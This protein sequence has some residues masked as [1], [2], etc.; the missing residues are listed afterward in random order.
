MD[1]QTETLIEMVRKY[2]PG[3]ATVEAAAAECGRFLESLGA[4]DAEKEAA[5]LGAVRYLKLET[6]REILHTRSLV[7]HREKWYR[8]TG[9]GNRHWP[10]LKTYLIGTKKWKQDNVDEIDRSSDE[11]V[12]LLDNPRS[13]DPFSCRGLVVGY[14]Q[15]GKTANMTAVIAKAVDAGYTSVIVLAGLTNKL[16]QQ[17]QRRFEKDIVARHRNAWRLQTN[18]DDLG[19]FQIPPDKGFLP[20]ADHAI[21]AVVKKNVSPLGR[22]IKTIEGTPPAALRELR[23]LVID[24]ECDQASVNS[25]SGEMN[26]TA[27]NAKIREL[28]GKLP[29]VSYVG[30]TATPFANVLINPYPNDNLKELDDLY[31][32]DFITAL[33]TPDGYFGARELFGRPSSLLD[34]ETDDDEGFDVICEVPSTHE[35]ALQPVKA[36]DRESFQ[37]SMPS[38]LEE[39]ILYFLA[40]CAVRR[41]RGDSEEHMSMLIHTSAFV[42]MHEKVAG[43]VEKWIDEVAPDLTRRGSEIADRLEAIWNREQR[44]LNRP[45][46]LARDISIDEIFKHLPDVLGHLEVPIENGASDDRIDYSDEE[47]RTYIIV[48][49]SILARGLTLEGLMVSYFLRSASQYDTLLQMG[50]WFGFRERYEDLPRIWM[51]S[52]LKADFRSLAGIEAEIREDIQQYIEQTPLTPMEFAVRIRSIPGMAITAAAKMKHAKPCDVSLWGK[53][54]QTIRF[55]HKSKAQIDANWQAGA[56]LAS[57]LERIDP[58]GAARKLFRGVGKSQIVRFLK[59]YKVHPAHRDLSNKFLLSFVEQANGPLDHWNVGIVETASGQPSGKPLGTLGQIALFNRARLKSPDEYADIKALMSRQDVLLDC[60]DRS[61][62]QDLSWSQLKE[63][64]QAEV[65]PV[66]L[67]LLYAIN[68]DSSPRSGSKDRVG[69]EATGHVLAFGLVLPGSVELSGKYVSVDLDPPDPEEL[70]AIEDE[71]LAAVEAAGEA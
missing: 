56:D 50:R 42:A 53:H 4:L 32:K 14:V 9:P 40:C 26:V 68:K 45:K 19:D 31:P 11:V 2:L 3:H 48:G 16:R 35:K 25:A 6:Q 61:G 54:L 52:A 65:G 33:P 27:I 7:A 71:H 46:T 64:R 66:P 20:S 67:L 21:L 10:A 23:F 18:D 44:R 47:A 58:A 55:D 43:L 22:L 49:G 37:P 13:I 69:L 28:L 29:R 17:T 1:R 24:D 12:S 8:G 62:W 34:A 57:A 30:Y 63:R 59:S 41:A 36:K 51:P 15:S 38:S 5:L 60:A 39:A 70:Q